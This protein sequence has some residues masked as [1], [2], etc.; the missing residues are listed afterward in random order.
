MKKL[1]TKTLLGVDTVR[2]TLSGESFK[3][4]DFKRFKRT[5]NAWVFNSTSIDKE[6]GL[7]LPHLHYTARTNFSN[8]PMLYIEFSLPKIAFGNNLQ[9]LT[10]DDKD[11]VLQNLYSALGH[12]GIKTSINNL[13]GGTLSRMDVGKNIIVPN[14][15]I[16]LKE[17]NNMLPRNRKF[18]E[19]IK[20][21][22]NG[23]GIRFKNASFEFVAYDKLSDPLL[24]KKYRFDEDFYS[25]AELLEKCKE[26]NIQVLRFEGR[27]MKREHVKKLYQ[28]YGI[29]NPIFNDVFRPEIAYEVVNQ[30]WNKLI[31]CYVPAPHPSKTILELATDLLRDNRDVS[32]RNLLAGLSIRQLLTEVSLIQLK[33]LFRNH[34]SAETVRHLFTMGHQIKYSN[35]AGQN[36][37]ANIS[38][39]MLE[40]QPLHL[41]L[42]TAIS[43]DN[44]NNYNITKHG[45]NLQK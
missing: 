31:F 36:S 27:F 5:S 33:E 44:P 38:K 9:E 39:Q 20:Y 2:I 12:I 23:K 21:E 29:Q 28:S 6:L 43:D 10:I 24:P 3:I 35:T 25:Q 17:M 37:I 19:K 40:W 34:S 4:L 41:P 42:K 13:L 8:T 16:A 15:I 1:T 32:L 14:T 18:S 45:E 11:L 30:E 22:N 26:Q 7:Y